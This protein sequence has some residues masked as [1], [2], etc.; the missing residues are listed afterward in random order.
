MGDTPVVA[1]LQIG[2]GPSFAADQDGSNV[3]WG[4]TKVVFGASGT[5]TPV[6]AANPLPI[7]FTASPLPTGAATAANQTTEITSLASI[8]T[9]TGHIPT[10][11]QALAAAST[12][13]VLTAIQLAALT[14]PTSVG[15]TGNVAITAASLPLPA[16]AATSALQTSGNTSLTTIATETTAIATNT[17]ALVGGAVPVTIPGVT[18]STPLAV[19]D[20]GT[21]FIS[22]TGN[23]TSTNVAVGTPFI[24]AVESIATQQAIVV[25][26][27]S[28][29]NGLLTLNQYQDAGGTK[30]VQSLVI[31]IVGGVAFQQSYTSTGDFFNARFDNQGAQTQTLM[32]LQIEYGTSLPVTNKG[33]L[34]IAINEVKGQNIFRSTFAK[35]IGGSVDPNLFQTIA[36]G[37]GQTVSQSAG[38]LVL[39]SGTTANSETILR[40]TSSFAG[41]LIIREQTT[42]SQRIANNNFFI[43]AVDVIGDGLAATASGATVLAVTIPSCPFNS[44]NVGQSMYIGNLA[45]GLVG[46]PNRYTIASVVGNVVTFTVAGFTIGSGTVS[47][48]GWNYQHILYTGTTATNAN[49]DCQR[50]GWNSGD[51]VLTTNTTAAPG[52]M[53]IATQTDNCASVLDQLVAS[54]TIL[55]T[56]MR[57]SRVVNLPSE[58]VPLFLQ[59]RSL[60]GSA[61]PATTSSWTLGMV[62]VESYTPLQVSLTDIKAVSFNT[63]APVQLIGTGAV[64]I[65]SGTI[66]TVSTVSTVSVVT[67]ANLNLP[68]QIADVAS[69]AI[70]T[71]TTTATIVPTFGTTYQVEIPVTVATG[72]IPTMDV[73]VQESDDGGTNWYAVWDFERITTTGVYRTPPMP[74]TGNRVRYVQTIAGTTPSF[75]RAINRIQSSWTH[76][77]IIR[78]IM[79]RT[80]ALGTGSSNTPML[81]TDGTSN[82]QLVISIGTVAAAPT[83]QLQGTDDG[84][85]FYNIG[86]PL[87]AVASSTVSLVVN[88]VSAKFVRA[89]VSAAGTTVVPNY[90]MIKGW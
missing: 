37:T 53:M 80:I 79:D 82:V 7:T 10:L 66:T 15:I 32:S 56:T 67:A 57:G 28:D 3:F 75:T 73:E 13:V 77:P 48:W 44:S 68:T 30:N 52:H 72:T 23:S 20:S 4:Y 84:I 70:T 9:N 59:I 69:A 61:A 12:P 40:S 87:L 55:Q 51:T 88:G 54:A 47:L 90:V 11:G 85:N 89:T 38:N 41:S 46:V 21:N 78:R 16:G 86:A 39:A 76:A 35:V 63:P 18:V 33:N 26:I 6:S 83:L 62:S 45:A 60:N 19:A 8:V 65:S 64:T 22:S 5:Q 25:S 1:S 43:E 71:T 50:S 58:N 74:L 29:Q 14:P 27:K 36:T 2:T 49:W 81:Y 34:P 24:G 17:P 42:L 31:P